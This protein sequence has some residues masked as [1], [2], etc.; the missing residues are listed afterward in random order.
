MHWI[1]RTWLYWYEWGYQVTIT[2]DYGRRRMVDAS[3]A[4]YSLRDGFE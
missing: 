1:H 2:D 3:R 4:R